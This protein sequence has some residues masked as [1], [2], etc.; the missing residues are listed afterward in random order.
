MSSSESSDS[1]RSIRLPP[2]AMVLL[3]LAEGCSGRGGG[4]GDF[5]GELRGLDVVVLDLDNSCGDELACDDDTV[6]DTMGALS[7]VEFDASEISEASD[8]NSVCGEAGVFSGIG[9]NK[10]D[11]RRGGNSGGVGEP[12][13]EGEDTAVLDTVFDTDSDTVVGTESRTISGTESGTV[14]DTA[15]GSDAAAAAP[16]VRSC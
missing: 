3:A 16:F 7:V 15:S 14:A 4:E 12:G 11:V 9:D 2:D 5:E 6:N 10:G 13:L 8:I 1:F